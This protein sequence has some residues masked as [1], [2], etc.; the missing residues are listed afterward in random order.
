ML[1]VF[2]L[3]GIFVY[4]LGAPVLA[5]IRTIC[6]NVSG[7]AFW[8]IVAFV[9]SSITLSYMLPYGRLSSTLHII[10]EAFMAPMITLSM[11]VIPVDILWLFWRG[12]PVRTTGWIVLALFALLCGVGLWNA[13]HIR[14]KEYALTF[15]KPFPALRIALISDLHLG[16]FSGRGMMKRIVDAVLKCE[17]DIVLMA[18]DLFDDR[19]E[20]LRHPTE[21]A[22]ELRRLTDACPVYACEGNHDLFQ[23]EDP[24]RNAFIKATGMHWLRDEVVECAGLQLVFRKDRRSEERLPPEP[25]LASIDPSKPVIVIDHNPSDIKALWAAGADLVLS[26]HTHGGQ[27][28]PANILYKLGTALS[29]GCK[30][31]GGRYAVVTSGIG[32][33]G[34]PIRLCVDNEV[35]VIDTCSLIEKASG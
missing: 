12:L 24:Q 27:T 32:T 30:R 14:R 15:F 25:M 26:G 9:M 20:D 28:F 22:A 29:Y 10:G 5:W 35:V 4:A 19:L 1:L 2:P 6:P 33:Y 13:M 34:T 11:L 23:E 31:Q 16:A 7:W 21:A 8:P 3:M 18:G 17:P